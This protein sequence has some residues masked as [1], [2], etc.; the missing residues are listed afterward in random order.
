VTQQQA[1][2]S[3]GARESIEERF[4]RLMRAFEE[5]EVVPFLGAGISKSAKWGAARPL[6]VDPHGSSMLVKLFLQVLRDSWLEGERQVVDRAWWEFVRADLGLFPPGRGFPADFWSSPFDP[7]AVPRRRSR[8]EAAVLEAVEARTDTSTAIWP[9]NVRLLVLLFNVAR[10]RMASPL[11]R[12]SELV[13]MR[14]GYVVLC[15]VLD[16]H[17]FTELQPTVAHRAIARLLLEGAVKE[18]VTTNYDLC[19][20][21]AIALERGLPLE[22]KDGGEDLEPSKGTQNTSTD[23][24]S[25]VDVVDRAEQYMG[26][27]LQSQGRHGRRRPRYYKINGCARSWRAAMTISPDQQSQ[28][29]QW[30]QA[31]RMILT[32]RQLQTFR[33]ERWAEGMFRDRARR[34]H[35][36]FSGFGNEEPQIRHTALAVI[37]E[38]EAFG[39]GDGRAQGA[40]AAEPGLWDLG[41]APWFHQHGP[42]LQFFQM[43]VLHGWRHAWAPEPG[44]PGGSG[45]PAGPT[46]WK[47]PQNA[48]LGDSDAKEFFY[49]KDDVK[50]GL[51]ADAFWVHVLAGWQWRRFQALW[52][53]GPRT[54]SDDRRPPSLSDRVLEGARDRVSG[55]ALAMGTRLH[56]HGHGGECEE[57]PDPARAD[58]KAA[59]HRAWEGVVGMAVWRAEGRARDPEVARYLAPPCCPEAVLSRLPGRAGSGAFA[60]FTQR[61]EALAIEILVRAAVVAADR[62]GGAAHADAFPFRARDGGYEVA[63]RGSG[64]VVELW[65]AT[66]ADAPPGPRGRR[67]A[68]RYRMFVPS[69][70]MTDGASPHGR[71]GDPPVSGDVVGILGQWAAERIQ[72]AARS[73]PTPEAPAPTP[74]QFLR[75]HLLRG[76][77]GAGRSWRQSHGWTAT[78]GGRA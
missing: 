22:W 48:F 34:A 64:F 53:I 65:G 21:R 6:G 44:E 76:L 7:P 78:P 31:L 37:R 19:L 9:A 56:L 16:L 35:L 45:S 59:L 46:P 1:A 10:E 36:L 77:R 55:A 58:L 50:G 49:G 11:A 2:A 17:L 72:R 26:G 57:G 71:P 70:V 30:S 54:S 63:A 69:G 27:G 41:A 61:G 24:R 66:Q 52:G 28:D 8:E 5:G 12:L 20:E 13:A 60:G 73:G 74:E 39:Q 47:P 43:Q 14:N 68:E 38:F 67:G 4:G 62:T 51:T 15:E 29:K 75:C 40:N 3:T 25:V 18:V 32:E 33:G 42:E 23:L